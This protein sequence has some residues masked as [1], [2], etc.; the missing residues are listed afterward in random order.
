MGLRQV[1][2]GNLVQAGQ[3]NGIVVVTQL[4]PISILFTVPEDY[5]DQIMDRVNTGAKLQVQAYDRAQSKLLATGTLATVDNEVDV[6]TGT[7]KLRAMFDNPDMSLFPNQFVNTK[8]LIDT[9]HNQVVVPSAA[10][11][12]GAEARSSMCGPSARTRP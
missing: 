3:T 5:I 11:Q 6:T 7:V 2:I 10:I 9:L 4:Q 8:L 1:D 12:N